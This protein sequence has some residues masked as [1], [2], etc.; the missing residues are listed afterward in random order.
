M[1]FISTEAKAS[2]FP[3]GQEADT[4]QSYAEY[5]DTQGKLKGLR[6]IIVRQGTYLFGPLDA[7]I[8]NALEAI[9]SPEFL[10]ELGVR[11]LNATSW[12]EALSDFR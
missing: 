10:E 7:S 6:R 9:E 2:K 3:D 8:S 12:Q 1:E 5:L 4:T 11:M